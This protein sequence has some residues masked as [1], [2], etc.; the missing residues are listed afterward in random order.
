MSVQCHTLPSM[1]PFTTVLA[2]VVII[3]A[4]LSAPASA[5]CSAIQPG[6][7]SS[8]VVG[9]FFVTVTA[10]R[11]SVWDSWGSDLTGLV[12]KEGTITLG[13]NGCYYTGAPFPPTSS[14]TGGTW[15]IGAQ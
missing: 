11:Q 5:Q 6:G 14:V 4:G 3:I 12:V 13:Q 15:M 10:F 9:H 7:E 2:A 1:G 8:D